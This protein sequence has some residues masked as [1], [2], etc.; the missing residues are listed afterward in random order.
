MV[1]TGGVAGKDSCN[2]DSGGPAIFFKVRIDLYLYGEHMKTFR[3]E[4]RL[5]V[6]VC[7]S[8]SVCVCVCVCMHAFFYVPGVG[9]LGGVL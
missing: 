5:D 6:L 2:G 9:A 7:V 8:V 4:T 1:C 3:M